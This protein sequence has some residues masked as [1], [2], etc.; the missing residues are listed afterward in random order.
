MENKTELRKKFKE[1]RRKLDIKIISKSI[2]AKIRQKNSYRVSKNVM[3]FYP[4]KYEIN[5]LELLKDDKNFYFPRVDGEKILVCPMC[6]N[7]V[8]SEFNVY[9]P[10]SEPVNPEIL[11]LILVPALAV[12]KNGYRL[13]YGGGFYDRFLGSYPDINTITPIFSGFVV[14]EIPHDNYDIRIDEFVTE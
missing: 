12:D 11:D 4:M 8:K 6:D 14:D 10:L 13:G 7:F 5:L 3:L 2:C 9:E 1:A